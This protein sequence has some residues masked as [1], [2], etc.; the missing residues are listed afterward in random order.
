[1][2][3]KICATGS[4]RRLY[5]SPHFFHR[6][7]GSRSPFGRILSRLALATTASRLDQHRTDRNRLPVPRSRNKV[8]QNGSP[9][10]CTG[11]GSARVTSK[12]L[13]ST[14]EPSDRSRPPRQR[15]HL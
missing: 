10:R 8:R 5:V 1:M 15:F 6:R 13:L 7:E 4:S 14:S 2:G 9:C 3:H 11:G 12:Q